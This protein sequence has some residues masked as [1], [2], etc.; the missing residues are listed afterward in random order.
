MSEVADAKAQLLQL[1]KR[2]DLGN[3]VCF[4]C[5]SPNPAWASVSFAIFICLSCAGVHRGFGVHISFIR[6][7]TMDAWSGD[8]IRRMKLGGN[9]KCG[10]FLESYQP[11]DQGGYKK[12]LSQHDKYHCWAATQYREKLTAELEGKPWEPSLPPAKTSSPGNDVPSR[13]LSSQSLRKPRGGGRT[14]GSS[15][16]GQYSDSPTSPTVPGDQKASNEAYFASLGQSNASRP[17]DLPPSQ[18]GRYQ[19]F[20]NTPSPAANHPS[21][22]LSSAAAPS[23]SEFQS[24]PL[25]ALNKSWSLFSAVVSGASRAVTENVIQPGMEKV[26]DPSFGEG[27]KGYVSEA[28]KRAAEAGSMANNWG[29]N[30]LG[31]DV[32]GQVGGLVGTL[33]SNIPSGSRGGFSAVPTHD[34]EYEGSSNWSG[35][36]GLGGNGG[37]REE[38]FFA[39]VDRNTSAGPGQA[40]AQKGP[41]AKGADTWG[42]HDDDWQDF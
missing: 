33:A 3:K 13:P 41:Q 19:G 14:T 9:D 15:A 12:S 10:A 39:D 8:Q 22:G 32:A 20:G 6:S 36:N 35:G 38:D 40:K 1:M 25:N 5:A 4:D 26:M 2:D 18:G 21:F 31:V 24:D 37:G 34:D 17:A 7:C 30:Q 16:L 23:I 11:A 42:N 29:K 28:S 27:L